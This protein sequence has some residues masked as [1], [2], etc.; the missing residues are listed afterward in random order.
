MSQDEALLNRLTE[1]VLNNLAHEKFSIEDLAREI[2]VSRSQLH[3]KLKQLTDKSASQFI[4]AIRLNEAVKK[5]QQDE[6]STSEIAYQVGFSSP[7]YFH[8]C[9]QKAFGVSPGAVRS[10]AANLKP[11][12]FTLAGKND[13]SVSSKKFGKNQ[14][15]LIGFSF[16]VV[17]IALYLIYSTYFKDSERNENSIAILPL[18]HLSAD[19][20]QEYLTAGLHDALISKFGQVSDLRIISRT[21]TLKYVDNGMTIPEIAEELGVNMILEG[22][23]LLSGDSMRLQANLIQAF[24]R[25]ENL[26]TGEYNQILENVLNVQRDI[27]RDIVMEIQVKL[28]PEETERLKKS[29]TVNPETYK[30]YV[31][32][33]HYLNKSTPEDL[34]TGLDILKKAI[35][36]D[37]AEPLAY[38]GLAMGYMILGH[39]PNPQESFWLMG[40]NLAEKALKLDPNLVEA[41]YVLALISYYY[42]ND[43]V[44]AEEKFKKVNQLNPSM[45]ENH[46]HYAWFLVTMGKNEEAVQEHILAKELD[47]LTSINT[48]DLGNLYYWV[49]QLDKG[50]VEVKK[51]L[52]MDPEFAHAWWSLGRMHV[53]KKRYSE[54]LACVSKAVEINSDWLWA[55][56]PTYMDCGLPEKADSIRQLLLKKTITPRH[57]FGLMWLNMSMGNLEQA[58]KWL[59]HEPA[60]PWTPSIRTWPDFE[61]LR[62]DPR[63]ASFLEAKDLPPLD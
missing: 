29:R 48:A 53:Q 55:M 7:T 27:V 39:G 23:L 36:R 1:V 13:E 8:R 46:F 41:H 38:A 45:S 10:G 44:T 37:P 15:A 30:A 4:R 11:E 31:L 12:D 52:E 61:P 40:K 54:A 47:P 62:K 33:M 14:Q 17:F 6:S 18:K 20:E 5:L 59:N 51:S 49:G 16:L 9:F 43:W 22:S 21:S 2:G 26:W 35:D 60:D 19:A 63:F 50:I 3:R 34:Q 24:P 28:T 58:F 56:G 25:E 57:A 42:A 32:G